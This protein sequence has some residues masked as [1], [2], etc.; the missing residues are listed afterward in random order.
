MNIARTV[1]GYTLGQADMLR[2][3]MGKKKVEVMAEHKKIFLEGAEKNGFDRKKDT[4][5]KNRRVFTY[6]QY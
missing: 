1:A 5:N 2:R 3:A 4:A 6:R